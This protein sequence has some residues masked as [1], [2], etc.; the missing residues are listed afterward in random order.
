MIPYD[1][2]ANLAASLE[3]SKLLTTTSDG[4]AE[5]L[6]RWADSSEKQAVCPFKQPQLHDI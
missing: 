6:K 5:K 3:T 1:M 4:Y 2:I